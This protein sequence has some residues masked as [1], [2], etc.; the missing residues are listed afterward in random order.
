DGPGVRGLAPEAAPGDA[1]VGML[2]RDLGVEFAFHS[3]DVDDP[4]VAGVIELGDGDDFFQEVGEA[5]ELRPLVV[6]RCDGD[7]DIHGLDYL[8]HAE[9]LAVR[10]G[11]SSHSQEA[12]F[13]EGVDGSA[14]AG[15]TALMP[16]TSPRP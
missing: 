7:V 13:R 5:L 14:P 10:S 15:Q 8:R 2:L 11:R 16:N 1:L 9:L 12:R 4:V 6:R 3:A